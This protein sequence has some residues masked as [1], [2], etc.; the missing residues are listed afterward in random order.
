MLDVTRYWT[1]EDSHRQYDANCTTLSSGHL[2]SYVRTQDMASASFSRPSGPSN[3]IHDLNTFAPPFYASYSL[4]SALSAIGEPQMPPVDYP[5]SSVVPGS[6]N[7][8]DSV[9]D[10]TVTPTSFNSHAPLQINDVQIPPMEDDIDN[11]HDQ[12]TAPSEPDLSEEVHDVIDNLATAVNSRTRP[13]LKDSQTPNNLQSHAPAPD[14]TSQ[15]NAF[16]EITASNDQ[17]H[18]QHLNIVVS[19]SSVSH[20]QSPHS[21]SLKF[22]PYYP[23]RDRQRSAS[24][25]RTDPQIPL[26]L[27]ADLS[28]TNE[29]VASVSFMLTSVF[30]FHPCSPSMRPYACGHRQCWPAD[31]AAMTSS[32][33]FATSRELS[34]H[35]KNDHAHDVMG[36]GQPFRCGLD[37]CGKSWKSLNGLQY[38]LQMYTFPFLFDMT[39]I[40]LF[41]PVRR[42]IFS[43]R[44]RQHRIPRSLD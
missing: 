3:E 39:L 11:D 43:K 36:G 37:G 12:M 17:P 20:S 5:H 18:P 2:P 21:S 4:N 26:R 25:R 41:W 14:S 15:A 42:L 35:S 1:D 19:S 16:D 44:C 34:D 32:A 10:H 27:N 33:C 28:V 40:L 9:Q 6:F 24:K 31:S 22:T 13:H 8:P 29:Y 38:H 7:R 30:K 23:S